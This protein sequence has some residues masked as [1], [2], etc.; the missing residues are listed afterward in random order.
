MQTNRAK[1]VTNEAKRSESMAKK[2]K[3]CLKMFL[4]N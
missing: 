2:E 3:S 1:P 4:E